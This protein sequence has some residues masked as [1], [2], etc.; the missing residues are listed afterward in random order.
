MIFIQYSL[1]IVLDSRLPIF[2][3]H[4]HRNFH[5]IGK[6]WAQPCDNV[7]AAN[8]SEE[9]KILQWI[10]WLEKFAAWMGITGLMIH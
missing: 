9:S 4:S 3:S 6:P 10:Y 1:R 8:Q 7:K 5:R 2:L